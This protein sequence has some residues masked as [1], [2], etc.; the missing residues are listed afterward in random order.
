MEVVSDGVHLLQYPADKFIECFCWPSSC[1]FTLVA[2]CH[3]MLDIENSRYSVSWVD[4]EICDILNVTGKLN[5]RFVSKLRKHC[6][7]IFIIDNGLVLGKVMYWF[8][9]TDQCFIDI[10]D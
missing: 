6:K 9:G 1:A 10:S 2:V 3:S 7:V 4:T 5:L 8:L